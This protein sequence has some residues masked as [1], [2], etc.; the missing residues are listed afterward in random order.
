MSRISFFT[1]GSK[2]EKPLAV[3]TEEAI[4]FIKDDRLLH[5]IKGERA[6]IS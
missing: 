2:F 5:Q 3:K 4:A 6:P 1:I